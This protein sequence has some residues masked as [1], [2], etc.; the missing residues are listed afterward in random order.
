MPSVPSP[1]TIVPTR[2]GPGESSAGPPS[3]TISPSAVT[4]SRPSTWFTV[5]PYLSVCGPPALVADVAADRAGALAGRIG[6]VVKAGAGQ[7]LVERGVDD[8]RLDD[9]VAVAEIDLENLPHPREDDHHAAADRQAAAG[10]ARARAA[11]HERHAVLVA[12][13]HD[14]GDFGRRLR[15]DGHVRA[16]LFDDER[17]ALVR[18]PGR[19]GRP[20]RDRGRAGG[21]TRQTD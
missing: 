16:V 17:V 4:I 10:Q 8:A 20:A 15:K 14:R 6:G 1:P 21:A 2:S 11:R 9:G 18:R 3:W 19:N 7:V 12:Q 5:T 13:L